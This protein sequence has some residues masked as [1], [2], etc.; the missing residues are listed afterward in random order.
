M[1]REREN[2]SAHLKN[3]EAELD[4]QVAKVEATVREKAQRDYDEEK[5]RIQVRL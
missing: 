1:H 3:I 2:H 4:I 5:R